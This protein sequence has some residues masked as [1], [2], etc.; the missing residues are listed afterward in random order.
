MHYDVPGFYVLLNII[1][2][3][4]FKWINDF[5]NIVNSHTTIY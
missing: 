5:D 2:S 3:E 4:C 1:L